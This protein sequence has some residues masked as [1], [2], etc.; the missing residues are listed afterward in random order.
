MQFDRFTVVLLMLRPDSPQ[1]DDAAAAA[2]QDA[3]LDHLAK[4]HENGHLL[5][6][7]PF[8]GGDEEIYRGL[9]ILNVDADKALELCGRDPAVIAGRF[10]V[11]ILPWMLP[12]GAVS[13]SPSRF[14]HSLAEAMEP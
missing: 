13:F 14:P 8:M 1:L 5:A 11:K 4:L 10:S 9:C 12:G 3:H 2:L 7:G 6:A